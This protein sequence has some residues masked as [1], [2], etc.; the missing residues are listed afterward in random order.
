MSASSLTSFIDIVYAGP[1]EFFKNYLLQAPREPESES[2]AF[3]NLIHQ[4]FE[5]V[6]NKGISDEEAVQLFLSELEKHDLPS[7]T[8]QKLR[9]K[10]PIDL[11]ISLKEFSKIL[12]QGKAEVNLGPEKL[13]I[14]GVPVVGKIDHILID[15][16]S[17]T[18]EIFDYK[19]GGYRKE[20]WR[21]HATLYK[22]MLQLGFYKLLLNN[23]P[24]Y[25]KYKI[26]KAHILFVSPDNDGLVHDKVYEFNIDEEKQLLKLMQCVYHQIISLEFIDDPELF[27]P[28][29]NKLGLRDIKKFIEL[30]LAK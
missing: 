3:G 27:L 29:N 15:E 16:D 22:Y 8:K 10:G 19:T 4:V 13:V 5:T 23:S 24:T 6:T 28:A 20:G 2:L 30:L 26:N 7:D 21:S 14:S 12:R 9:E 18:I 1:Q 17:K 11:A 25:S